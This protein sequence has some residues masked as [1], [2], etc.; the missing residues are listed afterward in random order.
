MNFALIMFVLLVGTG[1]VWLLDHYVLR[2]GRTA[3][4]AEPWWIE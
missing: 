3:G 2:H 4:Q 1:A